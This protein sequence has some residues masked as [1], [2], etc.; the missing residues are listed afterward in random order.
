[1]FC[2]LRARSPPPAEP[3]SAGVRSGA[4]A[5]LKKIGLASSAAGPA[6]VQA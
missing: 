1:M 2:G 3:K 5:A 6:A 4:K